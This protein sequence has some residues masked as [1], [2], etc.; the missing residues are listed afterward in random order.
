MN[1][2]GR[3][4]TDMDCA[5]RMALDLT[6]SVCAIVEDG[7]ITF[8]NI[9]AA[10]GLLGFHAG[11]APQTLKSIAVHITGMERGAALH[12]LRFDGAHYR[13]SYGYTRPDGVKITLEEYTRRLSGEG[14]HANKLLIVWRDISAH[15]KRVAEAARGGMRCTVTGLPQGEAATARV[16]TLIDVSKRFHTCGALFAFKLINL[17]ALC[18]EYGQP[19]LER[20]LRETALRINHTIAAPDFAVR[21]SDNIFIAGLYDEADGSDL[22]R[23]SA[24]MTQ[25][26]DAP[27]I[28]QTGA[29]QVAFETAHLNLDEDSR[30]ARLAILDV[31]QSLE[32]E[33]GKVAPRSDDAPFTRKDILAA[34]DEQRITL[35]YQPIVNAR[36]GSVHH[37]EALLRLILPDG[38]RISAWPL[39]DAAE[40]LQI[41]HLLD[42]RAL[43]IASTTLSER[44]NIHLALNISAAT[45]Q[46]SEAARDYIATLNSLGP[47]AEQLTIE[48][49][50]TVALDD[51]S[52]ASA[53]SARVRALGCRFAVDDFGAGHTSFQ[54]L[55][56]IEADQIKID[57]GFIRDIAMTPHKQVFVKMIV[58]MA[59]TFDVKTVA[60]F[61]TNDA[62]A[63]M[64]RRYGVDYL[65][66][67]LYGAPV[68]APDW[69]LRP[70]QFSGRLVE[71]G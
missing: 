29:V 44:D 33:N 11:D 6:G 52:S 58:D 39:I 7:R 46:N 21:V 50:E 55:L 69:S 34:L 65:Q 38:R 9:C 60:E 24:V 67:Y 4:M 42:K 56:A 48:L 25:V 47:L 5:A 1:F 20:I 57:G 8:E 40:R 10:E 27:F 3:D 16:Q 68:A 41:V 23:L 61:V 43:D 59:K 31:I 49:T 17:D 71:A 2:A 15:V 35:A 13:I 14:E 18:H 51:P 64:L 22:E 37:F 66:G 63:D 19:A 12:T 54:N 32:G 26:T 53:F 28:V 36:D 30:D 62:D 70:K 45:L